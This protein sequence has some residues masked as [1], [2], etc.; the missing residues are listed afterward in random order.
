[1][2]VNR[3]EYDA[4]KLLVENNQRAADL[5]QSLT[6][7]IH[8]NKIIHYKDFIFLSQDMYNGIAIKINASDENL[9]N[10]LAEL[11]WYKV[12]YHELRVKLDG[13]EDIHA[14]ADDT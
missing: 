8:S 12:K 4:L 3:D 6:R 7:E 1:M 9:R 13:L 14:L 2:W 10:A 11:E 5:L